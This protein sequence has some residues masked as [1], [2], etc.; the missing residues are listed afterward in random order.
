[1]YG[2]EAA[3]V[4]IPSNLMQSGVGVVLGIAVSRSVLKSLSASACAGSLNSKESPWNRHSMIR[5][6]VLDFGAQYSH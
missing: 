3:L 2:F 5:S 6:S 4:E 1:V